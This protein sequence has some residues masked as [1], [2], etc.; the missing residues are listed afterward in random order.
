MKLHKWLKYSLTKELVDYIKTGNLPEW[1]ERAPST[2]KWKDRCN[3]L[4]TV[5]YDIART[6]DYKLS[7]RY[8]AF[9]KLANS[10]SD[11]YHNYVIKKACPVIEDIA[12]YA[13]KLKKTLFDRHSYIRKEY[14]SH[15]D[16]IL[17]ALDEGT[18][19]YKAASEILNEE[20]MFIE[21]KLQ[22]E[23]AEYIKKFEQYCTNKLLPLISSI[24]LL[25]LIEIPRNYHKTFEEY[26]KS[27]RSYTDAN[28]IKT[29][30]N[31][32]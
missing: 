19:R 21:T 23:V 28:V 31:Q 20:T 3:K 6:V 22:K 18:N 24:E 27:K 1:V 17:E 9:I 5:L 13:H 7:E 4:E 32:L 14:K 30:K 29:I 11:E 10:S 2:S 16:E 25:P 12:T 8:Q 26:I 15:Q